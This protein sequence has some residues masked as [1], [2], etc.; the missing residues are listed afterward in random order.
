M[1]QVRLHERAL[2]IRSKM[3]FKFVHLT[4]IYLNVE[5]KYRNMTYIGKYI[6]TKMVG[7]EK[8]EDITKLYKHPERSAEE[9]A[10]FEN[11]H[12]FGQSSEK[13]KALLNKDDKN[14]LEIG[15]CSF[16]L[17]HINVVT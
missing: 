4:F 5:A 1:R 2:R 15:M 3:Y 9:R 14:D 6:S 17:Y 12:N 16:F 11:A 7:E 8:R 13:R 10:A